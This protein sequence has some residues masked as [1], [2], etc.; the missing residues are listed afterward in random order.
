M[1]GESKKNIITTIIQYAVSL[2]KLHA[3]VCIYNYFQPIIKTVSIFYNSRFGYH[4]FFLNP[5]FFFFPHY[6]YTMSDDENTPVQP[7]RL[8]MATV[9][10]IGLAAA[11][12]LGFSGYY[13]YTQYQNS[14]TATGT[15]A[16]GGAT[17]PV[18]TTTTA[19]TATTPTPVTAPAPA[20][21]TST[22]I[23]GSITSAASA[24]VSAI[25]PDT[26]TNVVITNYATI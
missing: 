3:C 15:A 8:G 1:G 2:Y 12:V 5:L 21:T 25:V 6:I 16:T 24:I 7:S 20:P 23:L 14:T 17:T 22:G 11:G 10:A 26:P 13:A 19:T 18:T 4:F 9:S